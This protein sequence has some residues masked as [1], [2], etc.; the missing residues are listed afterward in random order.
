MA[1]RLVSVGDDLTLPPSVK[2]AN[3]NLPAELQPAT[4]T[5][6]VLDQI[7]DVSTD[8]AGPVQAAIEEGIAPLVTDPNMA[9]VSHQVTQRDKRAI[10]IAVMG[11]SSPEGAGVANVADRYIDQFGA[12]MNALPSA[13]ASLPYQ[14]RYLSARYFSS[15]LTDPVVTGG[16][17]TTAWYGPGGRDILLAAGA[18]GSGGKI[19]WSF[20]G[21][22]VR[23][24]H[25]IGTSSSATPRVDIDGAG[26]YATTLASWN[27]ATLTA[28]IWSEWVSLGT[29]GAHT[30]TITPGGDSKTIIV[31]GM[32]VSQVATDA[33]EYGIQ[34]F[35]FA[36]GSTDVKDWMDTTSSR[37]TYQLACMAAIDPDII[38]YS[39]AFSNT[40]Y[41]QSLFPA[42]VAVDLEAIITE[43]GAAAGNP[44]W[45]LVGQHERAPASGPFVGKTWADFLA[46]LKDVAETGGHGYIDMTKRLPPIFD[47][48]YGIYA[49][50]AHLNED[51]HAWYAD[52]LTTFMTVR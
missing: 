9:P 33:E 7:E 52:I 3:A 40:F 44:P 47:D 13:K 18:V 23:F 29:L 26:T 50:I 4:L 25:A 37:K 41:G 8:P 51:G 11:S 21:R 45:V 31:S 30:V 38:I 32:E 46:A 43:Y 5:A 15:S 17:E 42:T 27:N 14:P 20:T 24:L 10:R 2:V 36:R 12:R 22:R 49:D 6:A 35:D 48:P 16:T 19:T 39:G 28:G 34:I 1:N